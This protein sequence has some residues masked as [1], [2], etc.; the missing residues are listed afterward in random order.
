LPEKGVDLVMNLAYLD[1]GTGSMIA[2]AIVG[3][4]AGALVAARMGW[5]R[6]TGV[7]R[8]RPK[9]EADD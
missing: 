7:F 8:R 3:G 2:S 5:R 9:T 1:P 4:L 6:V